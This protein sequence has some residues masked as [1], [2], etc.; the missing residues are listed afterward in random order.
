MAAGDAG[1]AA[2]GVH[3][4]RLEGDVAHA[5]GGE[6]VD[7]VV[8]R[9]GGWDAGGDGDGVDGQAA[10]A[11]LGGEGQL[12][13]PLPRVEVE[14][15]EG[16]APPGPQLG[17]ELA[18]ASLKDG[19]SWEAAARKLAS[20][21]GIGGSGH[22]IDAAKG[23]ARRH[24]RHHDRAGASETGEAG[25][26]LGVGVGAAVNQAGPECGAPVEVAHDPAR[27]A[28]GSCCRGLCESLPRGTGQHA[29]AASL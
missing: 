21:A 11:Q 4:A 10:A 26:E 19:G 25:Q 22:E 13:G 9:V 18:H 24:A 2:N 29:H 15:V 16:D 28:P 1:H 6:G 27:R 3:R 12:E 8:G 7:E 5:A 14:E 20:V 23:R 17:R